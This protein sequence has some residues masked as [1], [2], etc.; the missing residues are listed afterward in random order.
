MKKFIRGLQLYSR[1]L[2]AERTSL[3][4]AVNGARLSRFGASCWSSLYK[5]ASRDQISVHHSPPMSLATRCSPVRF[6]SCP[7]HVRY[8]PYPIEYTSPV[9]SSSPVQSSPVQSSPVQSGSQ[10][11]HIYQSILPTTTLTKSASINYLPIPI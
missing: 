4:S 2:F 11:V 9:D 7:V 8:Y 1:V 6:M 10:L 3:G 5:R